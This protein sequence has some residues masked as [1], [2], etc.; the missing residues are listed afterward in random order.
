[1]QVLPVVTA[2]IMTPNIRW[3]VVGKNIINVSK[4]PAAMYRETGVWVL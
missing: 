3:H 4:G 2:N 1:M